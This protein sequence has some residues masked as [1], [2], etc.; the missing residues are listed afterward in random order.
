MVEL[1]QQAKKCKFGESNDSLVESMI[2]CKVSTSIREKRRINSGKSHQIMPFYRNVQG[3]KLSYTKV[4]GGM[5]ERQ[6]NGRSQQ[7]EKSTWR[8]SIRQFKY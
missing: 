4:D 1:K 7:A 6:K 2:I 3:K 5:Q 8:K